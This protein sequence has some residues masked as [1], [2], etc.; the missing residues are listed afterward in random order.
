MQ[1]SLITFSTHSKES[2]SLHNEALNALQ[3]LLDGSGKG[4]DF[5]GWRDLPI[6]TE[7]LLLEDIIRTAEALKKRCDRIVCVGIGGS[8]LGARAAIEA[9]SNPFDQ[10]VE[11]IFAGNHMEQEYLLHLMQYLKGSNWGI[12]H[13]SKS[14]TTTEPAIAFRLLRKQL[15]EEIGK[16]AAVERIVVITDKQKG[17]LHTLAKKEGWKQFV[18]P[19]DVGGRFSVLTS[20]GLLPMALAGIDIRQMMQGARIEREALLNDHSETNPALCYA[21]ARNYLY[22]GGKKCEILASFTPRLH[23]FS[24]WWKQLFAESE[25]KEHKALFTASV[26]FTTDLHSLGQ[27]IQD[28]ER[29]IFETFLHISESRELLP[30]PSD[31]DNLDGLNYLVGKSLHQVNLIAEEATMKAHQMGGVPCIKLSIE[32]LDAYHLGA[33]FFFFEVSVAISGYM[34]GINPFNQPGVEAYK[35]EMF[36]LLKKEIH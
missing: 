29:I 31:T 18:I 6:T 7:D 20:V 23:Y 12:I 1:P 34:L 36:R 25:G 9:L 17:A 28:G 2:H 22:R 33:L 13:T 4:N 15:E 19:D 10:K 30:I 21:T 16:E 35:Q 5:L 11:I 3:T 27:W 32:Q 14:G 26:D 8:Y 24:E